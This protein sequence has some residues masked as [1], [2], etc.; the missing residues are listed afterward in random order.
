MVILSF[1]IIV[2]VLYAGEWGHT[3]REMDECGKGWNK[4]DNFFTLYIYILM[5]CLVS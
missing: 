3:W 4:L 5:F 1:I 2:E